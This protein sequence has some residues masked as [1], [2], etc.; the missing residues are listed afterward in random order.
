MTIQCC[1]CKRVR[2]GEEWTLPGPAPSETV[3]HTYCPVCLS[4]SIDELKQERAGWAR[5]SYRADGILS[6]A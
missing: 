3:S 5:P 4:E 6:H 1:R 2:S